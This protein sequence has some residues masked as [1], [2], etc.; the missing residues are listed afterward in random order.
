MKPRGQAMSARDGRFR[1]C[2][3]ASFARACQADQMPTRSWLAGLDGP[4]VGFRGRV[5]RLTLDPAAA[6]GPDI[7]GGLLR[8]DRQPSRGGSTTDGPPPAMDLPLPPAVRIQSLEAG[9]L[10]APG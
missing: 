4:T 1:R 6:P 9:H 5:L 8:A 3:A 7:A 10:P 2:A